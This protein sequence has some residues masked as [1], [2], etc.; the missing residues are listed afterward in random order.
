MFHGF[1]GN[2]GKSKCK[3]IRMRSSLQFTVVRLELLEDRF[4]LANS[5]AAAISDSGTTS[6]VSPATQ[7]ANVSSDATAVGAHGGTT[8]ATS[9]P[10]TS[11][12][13]EPQANSSTDTKGGSVPVSA[14]LAE[15]VTPC[16]S[17][18]YSP[19][20]GLAGAP[21]SGGSSALGTG[22][23]TNSPPSS[24]S[25]PLPMPPGVPVGGIFK[26]VAA[27][28][29]S[30]LASALSLDP[31]AVDLSPTGS[32]SAVISGVAVAAHDG[33]STSLA[34]QAANSTLRFG[35]VQPSLKL[36]SGSAPRAVPVE[37]AV[38]PGRQRA[39]LP[40]V[41]ALVP[42]DDA[43]SPS[44]DPVG[45]LDLKLPER[46]MTE[47]AATMQILVGLAP[48]SGEWG[49]I[50]SGGVSRALTQR[51]ESGIPADLAIYSA[52]SLTVSVS[53]P[54]LTLMI[55]GGSRRHK[56]A[57]LLQRRT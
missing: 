37:T 21:V 45:F 13:Q 43:I 4:L 6:A 7:Q 1:G 11:D 15:S 51:D 49:M 48:S 32:A 40:D 53:A 26:Q 34:L 38:T 2:T 46:A 39:V 55:R 16:S 12:Q 57:S 27:H 22:G 47:L 54:G 44:S 28:S 3:S 17:T 24:I 20:A 41:A 52:A 36:S 8:N 29:N 35:V 25:L 14:A 42:V 50:D 23:V 31:V 10:S 30:G 33:Q 5:S 9:D 18:T 56:I 19:A